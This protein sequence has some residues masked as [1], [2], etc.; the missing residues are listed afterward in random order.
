MAPRGCMGGAI[1]GLDPRPAAA[2]RE[3]DEGA[4]HDAARS[5][6]TR[7]SAAADRFA[8]H[9]EA[10]YVLRI[11]LPAGPDAVWPARRRGTAG[12]GDAA[13]DSHS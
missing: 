3:S 7:G 9:A 2:E 5:A 13:S 4:D 1:G 11:A 12:G 10:A 6:A 8:L